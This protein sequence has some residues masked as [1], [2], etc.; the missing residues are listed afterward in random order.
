[1]DDSIKSFKGMK[2]WIKRYS[3][4]SKSNGDNEGLVKMS[5]WNEFPKILEAIL[6]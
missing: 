5:N 3:Y 4:N 1:M 6:F 2:I